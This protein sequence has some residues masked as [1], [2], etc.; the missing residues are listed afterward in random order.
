MRKVKNKKTVT[1]I[2]LRSLKA[3]GSRNLIAVCAIIL[4][5][6]L[7]TALFTIGGSLVEK[8]RNLLFVRLGEVLTQD[9]SISQ[10]KKQKR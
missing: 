6:V 5:S 4:T 2:A 9:I 1:K 10:R 8:V 3:R 7:F